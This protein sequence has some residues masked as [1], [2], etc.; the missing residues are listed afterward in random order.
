MTCEWAVSR[1]KKAGADA[2]A[3]VVADLFRRHAQAMK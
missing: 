2:V 3:L 1:E